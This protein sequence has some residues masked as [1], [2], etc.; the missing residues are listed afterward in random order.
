MIMIFNL[1]LKGEYTSNF[2]IN[3][4]Y[5]YK[6]YKIEKNKFLKTIFKIAINNFISN[7]HQNY[8][9]QKFSLT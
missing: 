4:Y 8:L 6:N 9:S 7:P 5:K 3:L 1:Q 2:K